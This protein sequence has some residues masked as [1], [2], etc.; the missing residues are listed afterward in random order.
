MVDIARHGL[1][2]WSCELMVEL[3]LLIDKTRDT[4]EFANRN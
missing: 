4:Y 1:I 2:L 3:S